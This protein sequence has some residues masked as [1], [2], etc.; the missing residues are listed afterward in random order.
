MF[1]SKRSRSGKM[2]I[3]FLRETLT[4]HHGRPVDARDCQ[5]AA[6]KR[7]GCQGGGVCKEISLL[8]FPSPVQRS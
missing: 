5:A 2:F 7:A 3:V 6:R 8:L 1:C 4:G